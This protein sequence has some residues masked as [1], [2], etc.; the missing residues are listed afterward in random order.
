[1]AWRAGVR[2]LEGGGAARKGRGEAWT[3]RRVQARPVE[4]EEEPVGAGE[5]RRRSADGLA[6]AGGEGGVREELKTRV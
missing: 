6:R 2:W 1:M 4:G 3:Q 5:G